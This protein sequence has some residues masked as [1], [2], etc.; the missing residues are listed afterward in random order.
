ML[1]HPR[2]PLFPFLLF[3]LFVAAG[4]TAA[5]QSDSS[6]VPQAD[7]NDPLVQLG[8]YYADRFVGRKTACGDIFRQNQYTAA[9][10]TIPMGTYLQVTNPYTGLQIVVKVNDRCPVKNVLDM[11]KLGVYMLG[12]KGSRKVQIVFLDEAEGYARWVQ[13]DTMAMPYEAYMAFK[14]RS[15]VR[16][17]SPYGDNSVLAPPEG[18]PPP[19]A[20][21]TPKPASPPPSPA[22]VSKPHPKPAPTPVQTPPPK[23]QATVETPETAQTQPPAP[24]PREADTAQPHMPPSVSLP[25]PDV[26]K[27]LYNLELCIVGSRQAADR[28]VSRLPREIQGK[29]RI[30]SLPST[31]QVRIVLM[32]RDNRAGVVRVQARLIDDFPDSNIIPADNTEE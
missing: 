8:T 2:S 15:P 25:P 12:I 29:T 28:A 6:A 30:E 1:N 32:L 18:T 23:P 26:T 5:A 20:H 22:P 9:H 11:T 7:G 4:L 3:L 21:P 10:K 16:R 19:A 31:R 14:D 27:G 17:I 13:Q 24:E